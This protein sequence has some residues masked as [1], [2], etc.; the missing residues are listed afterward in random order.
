[1]VG[2]G[3]VEKIGDVPAV[4]GDVPAVPGTS[5][6]SPGRPGDVPD[7]FTQGFGLVYQFKIYFK[8]FRVDYKPKKQSFLAI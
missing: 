7:F 8:F 3:S 2:N 5:P 4:P 6:Q 1:M